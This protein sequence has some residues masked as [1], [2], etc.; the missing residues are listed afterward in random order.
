ME[1]APLR[2]EEGA[3]AVAV[4]VAPEGEPSGA[5]FATAIVRLRVPTALS[6]AE[7]Q[8][9][10]RGVGGACK[11]FQGY[12][13]RKIV[14]TP[15]CA[16]T[17]SRHLVPI[18]KFGGGTAAEAFANAEAWTESAELEGWLERAEALGIETAVL[19]VS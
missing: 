3:A 1:L 6:E 2:D 12:V 17:G 5:C 9:Y 18:V 8:A 13:S 7:L 19:T 4:D 11:R 15:A 14:E 10:L 16:T